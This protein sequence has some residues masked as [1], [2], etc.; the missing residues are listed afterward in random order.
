MYPLQPIQYDGQ[1]G[2]VTLAT[3]DFELLAETWSQ[4]FNL[5]SNLPGSS[6]QQLLKQQSWV[7]EAKGICAR[8]GGD[9]A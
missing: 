6:N 3:E 2:T 7:N 8:G 4:V 1:N 9:P 5:F